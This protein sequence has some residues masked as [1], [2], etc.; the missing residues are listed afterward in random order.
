MKGKYLEDPDYI[1]ICE[2]VDK[3]KRS[4]RVLT[5]ETDHLERLCTF[6]LQN[7][8]KAIGVEGFEFMIMAGLVNIL[9]KYSFDKSKTDELVK[10][11]EER[12]NKILKRCKKDDAYETAI[13]VH[14]MLA[15]NVEYRDDGKLSHSMA[16]P[17]TMKYGVCDGFSKAF[18]F[19]M[20]GAG[21]PCL[22]V[23]GEAQDPHTLKLE[24]HAWN[25]IQIDGKWCHVDVTFDTGVK[26]NACPR[27]DY[28]GL[29]DEI[30]MIDHIYDR[31]SY[32][33]A[34][35]NEM[36]Y[37]RR[38]GNYITSKRQLVTYIKKNIDK[39]DIV[40]KVGDNV[41]ESD[42]LGR[43]TSALNEVLKETGRSCAYSY[44][45]NM[46]QKVIQIT[47]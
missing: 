18:K 15:R 21:I 13:A 39:H 31:A 40:V 16:A 19:L 2:G 7:S 46:K 20:D 36:E 17:L 14:D 4:I 12:K 26:S 43:I 3:G 28:F 47:V 30:V 10:K 35:G 37:Y 24:R 33:N 23:S 45:Y 41:P 5:R 25:M 8:P 27:Y 9:P 1:K 34:V 11:C 22:V 32:P 6:A 44:S 42:F 29:S 38:H